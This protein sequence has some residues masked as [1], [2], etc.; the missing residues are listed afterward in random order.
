MLSYRIR[1]VFLALIALFFLSPLFL[2]I[3]LALWL[4]QGNVFFVQRRPGLHQRPFHLIKFSTLY[5]AAPGED[6]AE[7]QQA[8]LTPL[9]RHLRRYSLDELPQLLNVIKGDM[10]LVGPRPLLMEYL[11]LYS[12]E[13]KRRHDV[14]PGITGLA[15][16]NG[17]NALS[18]KQRFAY[19]LWYVEH[20]SHRL[21]LAIMLRTLEK[22]LSRE[23]VYAD[24]CTTSPKFDGTN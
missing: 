17:R 11:F 19:D 12:P 22:A 21:D 23:G 24:A 16:I 2:L 3:C 10:S 9:G 6:E 4:S 18:F 1:D 15:Q 14:L 13:E 20:K 8:R 5:D 7:N